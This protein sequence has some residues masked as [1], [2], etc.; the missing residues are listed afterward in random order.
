MQAMEFVIEYN[1]K[2]FSHDLSLTVLVENFDKTWSLEM[3]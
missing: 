2:L 3:T 1:D